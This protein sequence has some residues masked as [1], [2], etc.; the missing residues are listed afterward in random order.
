MAT[1][2]TARL[3]GDSPTAT[4]QSEFATILACVKWAEGFEIPA[5]RCDIHTSSGKR[6]A[7]YRQPQP[8]TYP[9]AYGVW[10]NAK[11]T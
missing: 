6:I 4:P 3:S 5:D 10:V 8:G 2:Y 9:A 1:T 7:Q 11:I